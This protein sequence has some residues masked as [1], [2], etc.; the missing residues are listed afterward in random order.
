MRGVSE[1]KGRRVLWQRVRGDW[2]RIQGR[3]TVGGRHIV[4]GRRF[5]GREGSEGTGDSRGGGR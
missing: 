2:L 5:K 4:E 1:G 3:Q